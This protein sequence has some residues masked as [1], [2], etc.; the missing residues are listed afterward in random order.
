V[1]HF[2]LTSITAGLAV[3]LCACQPEPISLPAATPS[4]EPPATWSAAL[5]QTGG[6]IGVDLEVRVTSEGALAASNRRSGRASSTQLAQTQINVLGRLLDAALTSEYAENS[7]GCADCF[8]YQ[9]ALTSGARSRTIRLDDT[10][11]AGTPAEP[12]IAYLSRLRDDA[13]AAP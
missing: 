1:R 9:L 2:F 8:A 6:L 13:L 12:L 10:S 11:M 7:S 4:A 5:T 3:L